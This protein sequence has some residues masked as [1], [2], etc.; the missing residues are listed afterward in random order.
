MKLLYITCSVSMQERIETLLRKHNP[1]SIQVIPK[2]LSESQTGMPRRDD[3]IWPGYDVAFMVHAEDGIAEKIFSALR[4]LNER[5]FDESELVTGTMLN[6]T[7]SLL[8]EG[9]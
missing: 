7:D 2:V 1:Q 5:A 4:N 9:K 8:P 6:V 3:P